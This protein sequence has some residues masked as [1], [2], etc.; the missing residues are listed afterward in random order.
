MVEDNLLCS[1]PCASILY[2]YIA[3]CCFTFKT[4]VYFYPFLLALAWKILQ[5]IGSLYVYEYMEMCQSR[6]MFEV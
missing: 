2:F 3:Y 6:Q 5:G 4:A 1:I